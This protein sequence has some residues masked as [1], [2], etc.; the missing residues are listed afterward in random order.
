MTGNPAAPEPVIEGTTPPWALYT[1]R[2]RWGYLAV[3]FLVSMS[4]FYD[5]NVLAVLLEPIKQEFQVSDANLGLLSGFAFTLFYACFGLPFAR[6]AD[7]G[8]RPTIVTVALVAWSVMTVFCGVAQTF[9][10]LV[11]A[12]VGVGA[13]EAGAQPTAQSLIADYFPPER[14]ASALAIFIAAGAG[15]SA[16]GFGVGGYL[17]SEYGWRTAFLA[18]GV[19][20]LL[21]GLLTYFGLAEPRRQLGFP[22]QSVQRESFRETLAQLRAKRSFLYALCGFVLYFF[23]AYGAMLF[24]P[25]Y[26]IRVLGVP[27]AQAGVAFG[28][29]MAAANLVG[30]LAGGWLGDRLARHDVRRL[31]WLSATTCALSAPLFAVAFCINDFPMVIAL[32]FVAGVLLAAGVPSAFAALHAICGNRRRATTIAI[33]SFAFTLLG[34]GFG[35]LVT[36]VLSDAF[37]VGYG[38]AG[39]R[40]ALLAATSVLF[41]AGAAFYLFGRAMPRD[42]EH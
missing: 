39:L 10:Q 32:I 37:S 3:L 13:G 18:G 1:G 6:W 22:A 41:L 21:L 7:R 2:Q 27:I 34:S 15:G 16:L 8:H 40:Y 30:T 28:A 5:R 20:G 11:L 25:S 36:G 33:V 4:L 23:V 26:L 17:A 42:L 29:A 31:A 14:R 12:R 35:P 38:T 19:P 24:V 9:W